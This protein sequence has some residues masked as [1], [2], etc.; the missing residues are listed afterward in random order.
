MDRHAFQPACILPRDRRDFEGILTDIWIA[1]Y[2]VDKIWIKSRLLK[3]CD[4]G[5]E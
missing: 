4:E 3:P 1:Y 5:E 2:N